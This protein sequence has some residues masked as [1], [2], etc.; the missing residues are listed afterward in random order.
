MR[1]NLYGITKFAKKKWIACTIL[2]NA[3]RN[4]FVRS[5]TFIHR[6]YR[7]LWQHI[8]HA[9][10]KPERRNESRLRLTLFLLSSRAFLRG[11][12]FSSMTE[13]FSIFRSFDSRERS[14]RVSA[15]VPS[16]D[17]AYH[18]LG[19]PVDCGFWISCRFWH[20]CHRRRRSFF[21]RPCFACVPRAHVQLTSSD[22]SSFRWL[23]R[24]TDSVFIYK[25]AKSLPNAA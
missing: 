4:T 15:Y 2:R 21:G 20:G 5:T 9:D 25:S 8:L 16:R 7:L 23:A 19:I 13:S 10:Q 6:S 3:S 14:R 12:E 22:G 17:D 24:G 11:G 18:D 1:Y